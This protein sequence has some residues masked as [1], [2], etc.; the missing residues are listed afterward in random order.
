MSIAMERTCVSWAISE[1]LELEGFGFRV[2]R[3]GEDVA[4]ENVRLASPGGR[5]RDR[6]GVADSYDLAD[7]GCELGVVGVVCHDG[8]V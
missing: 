4:G 6:K 7:C 3:C 8:R 5:E 2:D 1:F